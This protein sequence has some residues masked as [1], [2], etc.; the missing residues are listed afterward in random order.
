[1]RYYKIKRVKITKSFDEVND[2]LKSGWILLEVYFA[3]EN[4]LA[5]LLGSTEKA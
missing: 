5:F 1:M 2:L 4:K 3:E